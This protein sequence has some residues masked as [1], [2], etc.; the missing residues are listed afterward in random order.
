[1]PTTTLPT[2]STTTATTTTTT[3]TCTETAATTAV[4]I[5]AKQGISLAD[6]SELVAGLPQD[7]GSVQLTAPWQP[8]VS[9]EN[10]VNLL[11]C[12]ELILKVFVYR[13]H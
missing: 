3:T 1:M 10:F 7:S 5:L 11:P 8:N 2:S 6:F 4:G 9:Y 13:K 12:A